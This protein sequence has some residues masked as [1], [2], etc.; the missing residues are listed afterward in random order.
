[1]IYF[2]LMCVILLVLVICRSCYENRHFITKKYSFYHPAA[3]KPIRIMFLSDLHENSYGDHNEALVAGIRQAQPDVIL[4]GGDLIIGKGER[5]KTE[6]AIDFL[7]KIQ[8]IAPVVYSFGNHET[9]V[10]ES[11]VFQAYMAEIRKTDVC[12]LNNQRYQIEIQGVPVSIYGLELEKEVY[13]D[14]SKFKAHEKVF[15]EP[16]DENSVKILLAHT[17]NLLE[18]YE[19]WKPDFVFSGHNHGGIVRL[20][21]K[22]VISTEYKI[23]PTYSYGVYTKNQSK[24]I[25]SSGAGTHTIKFRLFNPPEIVVVELKNSMVEN[26]RG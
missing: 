13:K 10:K 23:F 1:M 6:V 4:I 26:E 21:G 25:L 18:E 20:F 3:K 11:D 9:R 16:E 7:Q 24:L 22:G 14:A 12:V 17:P 8:T 5:I 2:L 15:F 19:K